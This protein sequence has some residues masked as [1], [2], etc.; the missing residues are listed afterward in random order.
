MSLAR[1]PQVHTQQMLVSDCPW[2]EAA[3]L[4]LATRQ[5]RIRA[6]VLEMLDR[7][8]LLYSDLDGQVLRHGEKGWLPQ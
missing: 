2:L 4:G 1:C 7:S 3:S 8:A 5:H 6:G